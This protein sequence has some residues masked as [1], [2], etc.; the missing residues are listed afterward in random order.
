VE[1]FHCPTSNKRTVWEIETKA[2]NDAI[3]DGGSFT[4]EVQYNGLAYD[5]GPI[6]YDAVAL[7]TNETGIEETLQMTQFL[8][9][10]GSS[11]VVTVPSLNIT[12]ILFKGDRLRF[13]GQTVPFKYYEISSVTQNVATLVELFEG[14]DGI[15]N[16]TTRHY[17]G[18]GT[19]TSSRIHCQ[20]DTILCT[21]EAVTRSGS[22]QNKLQDLST[23]IKDGVLVDRDGPTAQNGFIWRVT[24][25]NDA[26]PSGSDHIL[27]PLSN[28]VTTV[29]GYGAALIVTTK[30]IAGDTY[31]SCSGSLIIPSEGGL[32]KG[33][34]YYGRVIAINSKGYS[35]PGGS[36]HSQ[37]P[38]V[39]PG[40][41]T[42][43]VLDI[44]SATELRVMF[45]SPID[46]GGDSITNYHIEWSKSSEFLSAQ[47][48]T[49][50]YIAGGSPFFKTIID[51]TMGQHY[52]V[53]VNAGNSQGY[54]I[55]QASTPSSLNPHQAPSPPTM[56][57][58][59]V[60]SDTMVSV[61]WS[62][63]YS[64]GGDFI[65]TYRVEW[66]T[67]A[68][69]LSASL[70]P[71]KGY[72]DV[73]A[74]IHSSVTIELLSKKKVYF[75][76][77][78]ALNSA[79]FSLPQVAS[80]LYAIPAK[81]VPGAIRLLVATPG[82]ITGT[83]DVHWQPPRIPHHGIPCSGTLSLPHVCPTPYGGAIASS[84]GG[85]TITEY[86]IEYNEQEDF[87][88]SDGG[89]K[90]T[91]GT[92][93]TLINLTGGRVYYLRGLARNSVGSGSFISNGITVVATV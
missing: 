15:Q 43:V 74:S 92:M 72:F 28:N 12:N 55:I 80:P 51:L 26:L 52:F 93:V 47:S 62:A 20:V 87:G 49:L 46:N 86:E 11:S 53:R 16:K 90:T 17:G 33:L 85:D 35:L 31:K 91:T 75:V 88:G 22:M 5:S 30:L 83:V 29:N 48:S 36:L 4:L 64:N 82:A 19:P 68:S 24:F 27:K 57:Q 78:Y 69:F 66:D 18:R 67:T 84:D 10:N 21:V 37:A 25:L 9:V 44:V 13:S 54:G 71:N 40:P 7:A 77:V 63:P 81:Q 42:D 56:V 23:V 79:G 3:I 50:D 41:P 76:R 58:L 8:L 1:E 89:R 38:M 6:P 2:S 65:T 34:E 14:E 60:T 45:G 32:V 59:A 70:P 39:V 73:D 61:G